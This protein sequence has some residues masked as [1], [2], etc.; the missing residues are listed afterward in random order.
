MRVADSSA[1]R[2]RLS[3]W[4]ELEARRK[5]LFGYPHWIPQPVTKPPKPKHG[6]PKPFK[7]VQA[8][9]TVLLVTLSDETGTTIEGLR[10]RVTAWENRKMAD[11][12]A[13]L[14]VLEVEQWVCISRVD[15][16]PPAPHGNK[17]WRRFQLAPEISGSHIHFCRDNAR[18]G[19]LAFSKAENLPNAAPI[20]TEPQSFRDI[21][22]MLERSWNVDGLVGVKA[23]DWDGGFLC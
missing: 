7:S 23:P 9:R 12:T 18:I 10:L 8:K 6:Q 3:G 5:I 4:C 16:L 14:E 22:R 19:A 17:F 21:C 15:F 13:T 2:A 11:I 20:E 1:E